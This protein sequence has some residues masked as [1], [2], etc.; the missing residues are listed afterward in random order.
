M[1]KK[2]CRSVSSQAS[3]KERLQASQILDTSDK[4]LVLSFLEYFILWTMLTIFI[5]NFHVS[6][7]ALKRVLLYFAQRYVIILYSS[8]LLMHLIDSHAM[9]YS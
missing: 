1:Q 5:L 9:I 7:L 4:D 8:G 3:K 2:Q 6:P